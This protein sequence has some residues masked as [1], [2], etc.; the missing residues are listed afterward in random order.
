MIWTTD[1]VSNTARC[2]VMSVNVHVNPRIQRPIRVGPVD[3]Y[4]GPD[5]IDQGDVHVETAGDES[6]GLEEVIIILFPCC[7]RP[8]GREVG[9]GLRE[10]AVLVDDGELIN[11]VIV[12]PV[13]HD[14]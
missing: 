13:E 6:T 12:E 4:N 5:V 14:Q 8:L 9:T 7:L 1:L 2:T 10:S 3:V 11:Y